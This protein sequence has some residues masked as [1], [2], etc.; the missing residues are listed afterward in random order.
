MSEIEPTEAVKEAVAKG[1]DSGCPSSLHTYPT[2]SLS[3][4]PV[5]NE[6]RGLCDLANKI[7]GC[8]RGSATAKEM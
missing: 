2:A 7:L 5:K 1:R 4:E 6:S 8:A 3:C